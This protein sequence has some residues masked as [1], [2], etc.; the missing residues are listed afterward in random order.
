MIAPNDESLKAPFPYFGGK[1]RIADAVWERLGDVPNYVEPFVGSGATLL[2]RPHE[3]NC[4]TVNDL[5]GMVANFW[6][7]VQS[8]PEAVAYHA[9][10]PVNENDLHARHAWLVGQK[11]SLQ[12][13]LEGDPEFFDAKAAGWW[14]WG[15]CCWIGSGFCSGN[16]PWQVQ[17]DKR[18]HL[19]NKGQGVSRQRVHLGNKGQG[20]NRQRVHLGDKGQGVYDWMERLSNRLRLVRVCCGDWSRVCTATP[21]VKQGLTGVFLDPP[22]ADS[23]NRT[24][25]LYRKDCESVAHDVRAWAIEQGDNPKMRIALC[26]YEGEHDM[27]RYWECLAWKTKGGY[28]SQSSQGNENPTKERIWFSP[29]CL[30]V[31][32]SLRQMELL[33]C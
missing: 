12:E 21:T 3:P 22:Y 5:D 1:S 30:Q 33:P 15:T 31:T 29:H 4:E 26:G 7:A 6:R 13:R 9:D 17:D 24:S 2:R 10:H 16:G 23:A 19:G 8:D 14:C 27:P 20:V 18:V 28:A 11:D 25:D 32:K